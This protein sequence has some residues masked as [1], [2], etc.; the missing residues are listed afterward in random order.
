MKKI[1]W[2]RLITCLI[3]GS[4]ILPLGNFLQVNPVNDREYPLASSNSDSWAIFVKE[5]YDYHSNPN[6][7]YDYLSNPN[8]EFVNDTIYVIGSLGVYGSALSISS[9]NISGNKEWEH[10][11]EGHYFSYLFD[12]YNNLL[13]LS[14]GYD[15][16]SILKI[17]TSGAI[18]FSKEF[19]IELGSDHYILED[20]ISIVLGE[21]NSLIFVAYFWISYST[22]DEIFIM[23]INNAGQ[24]LWNT[25]FYIDE[26]SQYLVTNSGNNMYLYFKNNSIGTL[27][28]INSS[29]AMAWQLGL[30]N[31]IVKLEADSKDNLVIIRRNYYDQLNILKLNSTGNQ[32]KEILI[33]F[34]YGRWLSDILILNDIL[35]VDRFSQSIM[36]YDLNLDLKWVFTLVDYSF[37]TYRWQIMAQDSLGNVYII[38]QNKVDLNN[39]LNIFNIA[40]FSNTGELLSSIIW[41]SSINEMPASM[42]IDSD[43]NIYFTCNCRY[44]SRWREAYLSLIHI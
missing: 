3:I 21:N 44:L 18:T 1:V 14:S 7:P 38:N 25:S 5:D 13:I 26:F 37:N 9:F 2:K 17:N 20:S 31:E 36:C 43:N 12:N 24:Y 23:K 4:I 41:G 39:E 15:S 28:Q 6:D 16:I 34:T 42:V 40:K 35:L 19:S 8:C 22:V 33:N 30:E 32:I 11:I 10:V 29:G 27:T